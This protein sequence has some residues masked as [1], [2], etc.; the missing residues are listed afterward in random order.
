MISPD[1][2]YVIICSI[3]P[4]IHEFMKVHDGFKDKIA[5]LEK[6]WTL[7]LTK[8]DLETGELFKRVR[9]EANNIIRVLT[10]DNR[11]I[12]YKLICHKPTA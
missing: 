4:K 11:D 7:P 8:D 5:L 6:D 9:F 2:K 12:L 3:G 10:K 1:G